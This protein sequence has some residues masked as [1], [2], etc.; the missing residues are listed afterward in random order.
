MGEHEVQVKLHE[1]FHPLIQ[2]ALDFVFTPLTPLI[3]AKQATGWSSEFTRKLD[4]ANRRFIKRLSGEGV[5]ELQ[6][7]EGTKLNEFCQ[8]HSIIPGLAKEAQQ[9]LNLVQLLSDLERWHFPR[10]F[11]WLV[12]E[13]ERE[14]LVFYDEHEKKIKVRTE[15]ELVEMRMRSA[16]G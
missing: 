13:Y 3:L 10:W 11:T 2:R 9:A 12:E 1:F 15:A 5:P 14:G 16:H 4:L 6:T 8:E 7:L